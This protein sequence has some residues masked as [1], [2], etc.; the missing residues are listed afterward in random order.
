[1]RNLR[2]HGQAVAVQLL[3][4]VLNA[5]DPVKGPPPLII[6]NLNFRSIRRDPMEARVSAMLDGD[7]TRRHVQVAWQGPARAMDQVY[8]PGISGRFTAAASNGKDAVQGAFFVAHEPGE[9]A[10]ISVPADWVAPA[11]PVK[12]CGCPLC[13]S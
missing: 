4:G 2:V 7:R 5:M 3:P 11:P 9:R 12:G 13:R 1:M 10:T 6:G 8:E